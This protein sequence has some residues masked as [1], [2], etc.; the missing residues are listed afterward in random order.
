[1]KCSDFFAFHLYFKLNSIKYAHFKWN[2]CI[3]R[4]SAEFQLKCT[5]QGLKFRPFFSSEVFHL[6]KTKN[7]E[8]FAV[9]FIPHLSY[10]GCWWKFHLETPEG[11]WECKECESSLSGASHLLRGGFREGCWECKEC[12]NSLSGA[13]HQTRGGSRSNGFIAL[14]IGKLPVNLTSPTID[15]QKLKPYNLTF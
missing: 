13:S 2:P 3:S 14:I 12:E 10:R 15:W 9:Y 8:I 7:Y 1:M 4:I 11:C 6:R 5:N